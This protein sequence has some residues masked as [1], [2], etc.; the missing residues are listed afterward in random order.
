MQLSKGRLAQNLVTDR[1]FWLIMNTNEPTN[2]NLP[3]IAKFPSK[4]NAIG[5]GLE[6]N[7]AEIAPEFE[8]LGEKL[9]FLYKESTD[10]AELSIKA[11]NFMGNKEIFQSIKEI[12]E[13]SLKELEEYKF[14]LHGSLQKINDIVE[15]VEN[16]YQN[17]ISLGKIVSYLNCIN[18][19]MAVECNR[20]EDFK[21]V[22]QDFVEEVKTL[23]N[24]I[25]T[26]ENTVHKKCE[27][28]RLEQMRAHKKILSGLEN[29]NQ[30]NEEAERNVRQAIYEIDQLISASLDAIQSVSDHSQRISSQISKIVILIQFHDITRQQ[31]EHIVAAL[32]DAKEISTKIIHKQYSEEEVENQLFMIYSL[33]QLQSTQLKH[34]LDEVHL[35]YE[36][37]S[38]AFEELGKQATGLSK[39]AAFLRNGNNASS[40][41][42]LVGALEDLEKYL[43]EGKKLGGELFLTAEEASQAVSTLFRD[44]KKVLSLG[45]DLNFKSLNAIVITSHLGETGVPLRV[46]AQ[47]IKELSNQTNH[48]VSDFSDTITNIEKSIHSLDNLKLEEKLENLELQRGMENLSLA[49]QE[50]AESS[51]EIQYQSEGLEKEIK[52]IQQKLEFFHTLTKNLSHEKEQIEALK[53]PLLPWKNAGNRETKAKIEE[54]A[55]RY[56]MKSERDIHKQIVEAEKAGILKETIIDTNIDLDEDDFGDNVELF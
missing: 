50:F 29:L 12:S 2:I 28:V 45:K 7:F 6:R 55:A 39:M 8:Q 21:N 23:V 42:N 32:K 27:D 44:I 48:L 26:I 51:S 15:K 10:L 41:M 5:D 52:F 54:I 24:K 53:E 14:Q 40:F 36:K 16:L 11:L 20:R 46:L 38:Q 18:L 43:G 33:L 17:C 30:L 35:V 47:E 9:H 37:I 31:I 1:G 49:R 4:I 22:F 3:W 34:V 19:N 25:S 56:T 13:E